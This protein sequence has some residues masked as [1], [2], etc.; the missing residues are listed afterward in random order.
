[1]TDPADIQPVER[2]ALQRTITAFVTAL[3]VLAVVAAAILAWNSFLRPSDLIV[4]GILYALTG[5][6]ITV[7][8]HRQLTHRS[9]RSGPVVRGV[10]A[11][12]GSA[13]VEGPVISWVDYHR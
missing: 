12:L 7:G 1:M 2:E 4:F 10:L 3:P 11:I 13:A 6:G 8:F 9:F 5:L